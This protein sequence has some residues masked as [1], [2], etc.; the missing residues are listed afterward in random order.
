MAAASL[1]MAGITTI[2]RCSAGMPLASA[3]RGRRH[4]RVDSLMSRL[5]QRDHGL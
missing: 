5:Q 4:G 2:T 1:S 3:R